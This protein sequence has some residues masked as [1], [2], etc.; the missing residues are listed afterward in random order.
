[1]A[2]PFKVPKGLHND[3]GTNMRQ[4]P[5][6]LAR[7]TGG[8]SQL[9]RDIKNGKC[10]SV[11]EKSTDHVGHFL[12]VSGLLMHDRYRIQSCI[13]AHGQSAVL[14][15]AEDLCK[16][17]KAVVIK[18]MHT[19]FQ[20][21]GLREMNTLRRLHRA[22]AES[23]SH[24][25]HLLDAFML[26]EH[27]CLVFPYLDPRPLTHIFKEKCYNKNQKIVAIRK[28]SR[29]LLTALAFLRGQLSIHADVKPENILCSN[30]VDWDTLHLIDFGNVIHHTHSEVT[31]YFSD[32]ELQ[33]LP[34]R[35]PEVHIGVPFSM[36]IDMWSLG[37]VLIELYTGKIAFSGDDKKQVLEKIVSVLGPLPPEMCHRGK[38]ASDVEDLARG[39]ATVS[40]SNAVKLMSAF[41][42]IEHYK[43]ASFL[44]GLLSYYP[45]KRL[46]PW[47]ALQHSFMAPEIC[48][49][50][51]L[52]DVSA[53]PGV[54][55]K[56]EYNYKTNVSSSA[57]RLYPSTYDLLREGTSDSRLSGFTKVARVVPL[58]HK[59][60]DRDSKTFP[61][62]IARPK[63]EFD[64][65]EDQDSLGNEI[66]VP[67]PVQMETENSTGFIPHSIGVT[68]GTKVGVDML[69]PFTSA[70]LESS[71]QD[72]YVEEKRLDSVSRNML[73]NLSKISST[74]CSNDSCGQT[75]SENFREVTEVTP[76][77]SAAYNTSVVPCKTQS[78]VSHVG[79]GES[80]HW[81]TVKSPSLPRTAPI[82]LSFNTPS[83]VNRP[84]SCNRIPNHNSNYSMVMSQQLNDGYEKR[85]V[86]TVSKNLSVIRECS[87]SEVLCLDKESDAHSRGA[88]HY[89][90]KHNQ[91]SAA[92][93]VLKARPE[94]EGLDLHDCDE[95]DTCIKSDMEEV[96][97]GC[98]RE[99]LNAT[100]T[101]ES[102]SL[103]QKVVL[104]KREAG[105]L[106]NVEENE[107]GF[108]LQSKET[109]LVNKQD[110][111]EKNE[112][113]E[114]EK[115]S[116][117]GTAFSNVKENI[118]G[119]QRK[120]DENLSAR[121]TNK[122]EI[123]LM[124]EVEK[125]A[126][127]KSLRSNSFESSCHGRGEDL[128]H[129]QQ[130]VS[131]SGGP[132][133]MSPPS[134]ICETKEKITIL[135]KKSEK[136]RGLKKS[137]STRTKGSLFAKECC[138]G[139]DAASARAEKGSACPTQKRKQNL[140]PRRTPRSSN[141]PGCLSTR[142]C[143]EM[144]QMCSLGVK[145]S[146]RR[147]KS[148]GACY[149]GTTVSQLYTDDVRRIGE[150]NSWSTWASLQQ[151]S[152]DAKKVRK[153]SI[154]PRKGGLKKR[155][156]ECKASLSAKGPAKRMECEATSLLKR[157]SNSTR[158]KCKISRECSVSLVP[159]K[160]PRA[161]NTF[162]FP[163]IQDPHDRRRLCRRSLEEYS[164]HESQNDNSL[165]VE[166]PSCSIESSS[167]GRRI[168]DVS[169]RDSPD[170]PH[171]DE[172][173][174]DARLARP[175]ISNF[176]L[177]LSGVN[178][179]QNR[180]TLSKQDKGDS[181]GEDA[182]SEK[183]QGSHS[184]KR[185][186]RAKSVK[187]VLAFQSP[188]TPDNRTRNF[189][190]L[191]S[192]RSAKKSQSLKR[193]GATDEGFESPPCA[194]VAID[195]PAM[196]LRDVRPVL[197]PLQTL[198]LSTAKHNSSD[199]YEFKPSP[200]VTH[201]SSGT[202]CSKGRFGNNKLV[203]K[204]LFQEEKACSKNIA[205][206]VEQKAKQFSVSDEK[207]KRKST[208]P[209]TCGPSVSSER[210]SGHSI[211]KAMKEASTPH[212]G[213]RRCK[214]LKL[215]TKIDQVLSDDHLD[216]VAQCEP[217]IP[218]QRQSVSEDSHLSVA[219][220]LL[221]TES[222]SQK[223]SNVHEEG[224]KECPQNQ[225]VSNEPQLATVSSKK[226]PSRTETFNK[227][228]LEF[229]T[230]KISE[231]LL[232]SSASPNGAL[233]RR[234]PQKLPVC[235][236]ALVNES[237]ISGNFNCQHSDRRPVDKVNDNEDKDTGLTD[238]IPCLDE[239]VGQ[240]IGVTE[241]MEKTEKSVEL[242][243]VQNSPAPSSSQNEDGDNACCFDEEILL[244]D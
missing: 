55:C 140:K 57:Q 191:G 45:D 93:K 215:S 243:V 195:P 148:L 34:Y 127:E 152:N 129:R 154:K 185:L 96:E 115:L 207:R 186:H 30:G 184:G 74:N 155:N 48:I 173:P 108:P 168:C 219:V 171:K 170:P 238:T 150:G 79:S 125:I 98:E 121:D 112:F 7:L 228:H 231:C 68:S 52:P 167:Q 4:T 109:N 3:G 234:L 65:L 232:T 51:F 71:E 56:K 43:F 78:S 117:G 223:N 83:P 94:F 53:F 226:L 183:V 178:V 159:M 67:T 235:Q 138:N 194:A 147:A 24:C 119:D 59:V 44:A 172:C 188:T 32:F 233:L 157:Q 54:I 206:L 118:C 14:V 88:T 60:A 120:T 101:L 199:P 89:A 164:Y 35:A 122:Q 85:A 179:H 18:V 221:K 197:A 92:Q 240:P 81:R 61:N 91:N 75:G 136:K 64:A 198:C 80:S 63:S 27:V 33:T 209:Q 144:K 237:A 139:G 84:G 13:Q 39:R 113:S 244:L 26:D 49:Q 42:E 62:G 70:A 77:H 128:N 116:C 41:P 166:K 158:K 187:R 145:T 177:C 213:R 72:A 10:H 227:D 2:A 135:N 66:F 146:Q 8:L 192:V 169:T 239:P 69:G 38:Y 29:H 242:P 104:E 20:A 36:E 12:P 212:S 210:S 176:N 162:C 218:K 5:Q 160:E 99:A 123:S 31:V 76:K 95:N 203:R 86:A 181:F 153:V 205:D 73:R 182:S 97:W 9:Y 110:F 175:V 111:A 103:F 124:S 230:E 82:P 141:I 23:T 6:I 90:N 47:E 105:N 130:I 1:M 131:K 156:L 142:K 193:K 241:E 196:H 190:R 216:V 137:A 28:I 132:C 180:H 229:Q 211:S 102:P 15:K 236:S 134:A 214:R 220:Q 21:V 50:H 202:P 58:D 189:G 133:K 100:F 106:A 200:V 25:L 149:T 204:N 107:K 225:N 114:V 87:Q 46:T 208:T 217:K 143:T 40:S 174:L 165:A 22:D 11:S 126:A 16:N 151:I 224:H 17:M 201:G 161:E 19:S 222:S 163:N 37:C